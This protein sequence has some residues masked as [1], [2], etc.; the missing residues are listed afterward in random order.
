M[1]A[2]VDTPIDSRLHVLPNGVRLVELGPLERGWLVEFDQIL[3]LAAADF[4]KRAHQAGTPDGVLDDL[5]AAL[6]QPHRAVWL[7]LS[8]EY[9]FLGFALVELVQEFGAPPKVFVQAA[10][11]WPRRP[12]RA[13]LPALTAAI[14]AWGVARGATALVFQTRRETARAWRRVGA[15]PVAALYTIPIPTDAGGD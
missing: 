11:L 6:T 7:V 3:R 8:A 15:Q 12:S 5:A 1:H 10:Y 14:Q 13:V 9:R 4:L 2:S